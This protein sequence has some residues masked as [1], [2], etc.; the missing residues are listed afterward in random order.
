MNSRSASIVGDREAGGSSSFA[1][2]NR[3]WLSSQALTCRSSARLKPT[4]FDHNLLWL[5]ESNGYPHL[6]EFKNK[7]LTEFAFRKSLILKSAI[8]ACL[9]LAG[10]E[11]AGLEKKSGSKLPLFRTELSTR[12]SVHKD[13]EKSRR[14]FCWVFLAEGDWD[15]A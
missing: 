11:V 10:A 3:Q 15:A 4:V 6:Y 12:V 9:G 7:G 1:W 8:L 5:P 13:R 2:C 14:T